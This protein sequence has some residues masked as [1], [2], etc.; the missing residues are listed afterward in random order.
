MNFSTPPFTTVLGW[1]EKN[2]C[3]KIEITNSTDDL[4]EVVIYWK[5]YQ[6][7]MT[8]NPQTYITTIEVRKVV[9]GSSLAIVDAKKNMTLAD[10]ITLIE[11]MK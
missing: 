11:G 1:C 7:I 5:S 4:V 9:E 2:N 3:K 6:I 8:I 10:C